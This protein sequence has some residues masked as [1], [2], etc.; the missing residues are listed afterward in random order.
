MFL[1]KLFITVKCIYSITSSY[2]SIG[3]PAK[4]FGNL[5]YKSVFFFIDAIEFL[6]EDIQK[7][8]YGLGLTKPKNQTFVGNCSFIDIDKMY[9]SPKKNK[10]IAGAA[11]LEPEKNI[12]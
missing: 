9:I 10:I 12:L 8:Y 7:K 5:S 4:W 2:G 6:S 1:V 3:I 11:R